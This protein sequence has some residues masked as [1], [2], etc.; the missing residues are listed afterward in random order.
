[1]LPFLDEIVIPLHCIYL[2][3]SLHQILS[4]IRKYLMMESSIWQMV[5][6]RT[7]EELVIDISEGSAGRGRGQAPRGNAP[8]PPPHLLVMSEQ[9]LATQ[10]D[11]MRTLVKNDKRRGAEH[12]QHQHQ[13]RDSSYMDFLATHSP[14]F[15]DVTDPL[16]LDNWLCTTESKFRLLH[17]TEYLK[18]LY[19]T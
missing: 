1:M 8:P 19:A 16:E 12:P 9:L 18:T 15:V 3:Q 7:S 5:R 4:N 10:N 2:M 11:L 17:C 13:E 14:I 6:T